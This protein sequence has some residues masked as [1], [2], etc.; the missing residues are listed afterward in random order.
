M[1]APSWWTWWDIPYEPY[2]APYEL[3]N[4]VIP[5]LAPYEQALAGRQIAYAALT[6]PGLLPES[7]GAIDLS[8]YERARGEP[9]LVPTWLQGLTV[10]PRLPGRETPEE[11]W[12]RGLFADAQDLARRNT[13]E[14]Q[15]LFGTRLSDALANA[16]STEAR[17]LGELLFSPTFKRPEY[18]SVPLP[19]RYIQPYRVKGG[20]VSNPWF[21][22]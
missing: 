2:V 1:P 17:A 21:V 14:N 4:A 10:E 3:M 22:T 12:V 19:A 15:R 20:L 13:R 16:P 18:G 5:Y 7:L 8:G 6:T 11:V 9:G